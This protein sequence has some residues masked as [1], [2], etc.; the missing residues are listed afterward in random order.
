MDLTGSH[1]PKKS[2]HAQ[3]LSHVRGFCNPIDRSP[4]SSFGHGVSQARILEWVAISSSRGSSP[5]RDW[6]HISCIGRQVL[7][8]WTTREAPKVHGG[9]Q[10]CDWLRC[11]ILPGISLSPGSRSAQ[12]QTGS[13]TL[14][15]AEMV[16]GSQVSLSVRA[17][18][19]SKQ[20]QP[21]P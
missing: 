13:S 5:P 20:E 10:S 6:T 16:S 1:I 7:Y 14:R 11:L 2:V 15:V 19:L 17:H 8:H 21:F 3:S 9:S 12:S 18:H 4:P